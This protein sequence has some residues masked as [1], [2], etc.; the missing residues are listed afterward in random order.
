[1]QS[2]ILVTLPVFLASLLW[3]FDR[4]SVPRELGMVAVAFGTK[5]DAYYKQ[6]A[7]GSLVAIKLFWP[8]R[9]ADL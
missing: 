9:V 3:L 2:Y 6:G 4:R 8:S 1:M 5:L 7:C